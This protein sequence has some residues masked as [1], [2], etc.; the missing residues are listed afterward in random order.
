MASTNCVTGLGVPV[1]L[2][3]GWQFIAAQLDD[4]PSVIVLLTGL[5]PSLPAGAAAASG[6]R[7]ARP[8]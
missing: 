6:S 4:G 8:S 2:L 3:M 5:F 7:G 1:A